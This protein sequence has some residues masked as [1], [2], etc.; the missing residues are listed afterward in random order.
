MRS[1]WST[2]KESSLIIDATSFK[3]CLGQAGLPGSLPPCAETLAGED[4]YQQSNFI[5]MA[6]YQIENTFRYI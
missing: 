4:A 1:Y 2:H 6:C 5:E 3:K